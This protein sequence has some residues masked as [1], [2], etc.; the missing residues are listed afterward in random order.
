MTI[1]QAHVLVAPDKF[2]GSLTAEQVATAIA[3]GIHQVLPN[4]AVRTVPVADGGDGTVDAA[5][6]AGFTRLDVAAHGPTG[7]PI[8]AVIAVREGIAVVETAAAAAS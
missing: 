6:A 4:L 5:L 8:D 3:E 7:E 1:A 2:K